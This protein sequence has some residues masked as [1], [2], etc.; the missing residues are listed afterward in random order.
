MFLPSGISATT[1]D[2]EPTVNGTEKHDVG[3]ICVY[4]VIRENHIIARNLNPYIT[5]FT[6]GGYVVISIFTFKL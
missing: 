3:F 5:I 4:L 1:F 6:G 2:L